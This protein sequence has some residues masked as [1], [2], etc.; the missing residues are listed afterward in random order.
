MAREYRDFISLIIYYASSDSVWVLLKSFE[1]NSWG[2]IEEDLK[3]NFPSVSGE[4]VKKKNWQG[5]NVSFSKTI[6]TIL[7]TSLP[8]DSSGGLCSSITAIS[9]FH[10]CRFQCNFNREAKEAGGFWSAYIGADCQAEVKFRICAQE[11][12]TGNPIK[13]QFYYSQDKKVTFASRILSSS[14]APVKVRIC[15]LAHD[16]YTMCWIFKKL[17]KNHGIPNIWAVPNLVRRF[18]WLRGAEPE[19][20][21]NR[22]CKLVCIVNEAHIY[23]SMKNPA[24][25]IMWK[26]QVLSLRLVF[27]VL[28]DSQTL[29]VLFPVNV[30]TDTETDNQDK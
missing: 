6:C 7:S 10:G 20:S 30:G 21:C 14:L 22:A 26:V 5:R 1:S 19:K 9:H 27:Y 17:Q 25:F 11:W 8:S 2:Q 24:S 16:V 15:C 18:L 13:Q 28:I 29:L 3:F 4:R 12:P 23:W